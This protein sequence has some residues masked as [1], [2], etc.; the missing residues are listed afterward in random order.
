MYD[1][2]IHCADAA[3]MVTTARSVIYDQLGKLKYVNLKY[4]EAEKAESSWLYDVDFDIKDAECVITFPR[5]DQD[6]IRLPLSSVEYLKLRPYYVAACIGFKNIVF[7]NDEQ[8]E[9][10]NELKR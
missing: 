6:D 8:K 5:A 2:E 1:K 7:Y 4:K 10:S 9:D 3:Q